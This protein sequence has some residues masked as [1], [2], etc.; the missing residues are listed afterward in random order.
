MK[1]DVKSLQCINAELW[2]KLQIR[3]E[4]NMNRLK[5][6]DALKKANTQSKKKSDIKEVISVA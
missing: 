4:L 2:M 1:Q 5:Q 3:Y 6:M